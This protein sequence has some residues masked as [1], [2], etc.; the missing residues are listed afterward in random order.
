MA[1]NRVRGI[2]IDINGNTTDLQKSLQAVDK[3][4]AGT[5]KQLK[6][7]DKLLKLDPKNV[8]LLAQK[9]RL[10]G[11][12]IAE[13]KD[14][15]GT[16]KEAA[17]K[18][19]EALKQGTMSQEQ[20]D[21]L[22]RE[23]VET[24]LA[25]SD[26][27][28]EA[29]DT[30]SAL[31]GIADDAAGSMDDLQG[32]ASD[33]AGALGEVEGKGSDAQTSLGNLAKKAEEVGEALKTHVTDPLMK[34]GKASISSFQEVDNGMD[35]IKR[36]VGT[37]ATD[38]NDLET[39]Y[40][41]VFGSMPVTAEQ[42]GTAVGEISTRFQASGQELEDLSE[43]FLK[44][45]SIT[46]AD[47][48]NSVASVNK[49]MTK[50][51]ESTDNTEEVLGMFA[52][53]SQRTGISVDTLMSTLESNG[54][55]FKEMGFSIDESI[56]LMGR[57]EQNGVD[58]STA[59]TGMKKA[60]QNATKEG[61]PARKALEDMITKIQNSQSEI[62]ALQYA[63]ELFGSK[64]APEMVQAIN[65]ERF[66]LDELGT[67]MNY[68][69]GVVTDTFEST[70][71][72]IDDSKVAMNNLK[73]AGSEL[74]SSVLTTL[75]PV[76]Q[77]LA[78]VAK[79]VNE[80]FSNL[81]PTTQK[82]ITTLGILAVTLGPLLIVFAKLITAIQVCTTVIP[83]C[84]AAILALNAAMAA[85]P[86]GLVI[87]A[88]AALVAAFVYLWNHCEEFREFWMGLWEALQEGA[89]IVIEGIGDAFEFFGEGLSVVGDGIMLM[90]DTLG[91]AFGT[92]GDVFGDICSTTGEA[93]QMWGDGIKTVFTSIWDFIKGIINTILS[94]I[95]G[96]IGGIESAI[97][98]VIG[99]MNLLHWE[100]PSWVPGIG[101]KGFGF[102]IPE[103]SFGRIP[104]LAEGGVI[105]PNN[106][107]LAIM[108]DQKSGV[109]IEAPLATIKDA[110]IDAMNSR[111]INGTTIIPVYIGQEK[112]DTV[113]ARAN[114][115]NNYI[116]G[117]R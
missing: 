116:S 37:I 5:Q 11:D 94:G 88:I 108:G 91:S 112:I 16:L 54:A 115:N 67:S 29:N 78:D 7:V 104:Y 13:T 36:K 107:F 76:I 59:M 21:A 82:I 96:M 22:K 12:A 69:S 63:T 43:L 23:I 87:T 3:S 84:K 66:S 17:E 86:I 65:E 89:S 99:G 58:V 48:E 68:F 85:N 55:Q 42:A 35:I 60:V 81:D 10:L 97:N 6:D 109:N 24:E 2:T 56:E 51:G 34:L 110:L 46:G 25:L 19:D 93:F 53:Q 62:G 39:V 14:K 47:V 83:A 73:L 50:F 117:G 114:R 102:N 38:F 111:G 74:G 1:S 57:L 64:G 8:E 49:I 75:T 61:V 100:I 41:N 31:D 113:V 71:D 33:A 30:N 92:L 45:S 4:L 26:L 95:N 40:E 103:V 105:P 72:P 44:F 70:L 15:L 79:K 9:Q 28:S 52:N 98:F 20:Y 77:G 106:P 27:E 90:F 80:W 18:A 101:G 32:S